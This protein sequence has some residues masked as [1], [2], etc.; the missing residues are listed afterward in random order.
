M[1]NER[2]AEKGSVISV[3]S[4]RIPLQTGRR[5][6]RAADRRDFVMCEATQHRRLSPVRACVLLIVVYLAVCAALFAEEKPPI[7]SE[8]SR[9]FPTLF[10]EE[11]TSAR[12][13]WNYSVAPVDDIRVRTQRTQRA[14][15]IQRAGGD[16]RVQAF[17]DSAR[18][19]QVQQ[20]REEDRKYLQAH[21]RF[22]GSGRSGYHGHRR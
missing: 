17:Y 15:R 16:D 8:W 14:Q 19:Q 2:R 10:G 6:R 9:L 13:E 5:P 3:Q 18:T 4:D 11:K 7:P 1:R 22:V 20:Q 12:R 21:P